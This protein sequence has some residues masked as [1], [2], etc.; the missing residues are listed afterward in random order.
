[1]STRWNWLV[2]SPE[3][4]TAENRT[5]NAINLVTFLLVCLFACIQLSVSAAPSAVLFLPAIGLQI[6]LYYFSRVHRIYRVPIIL[7]GVAS[8]AFIISSYFLHGGVNGPILLLFFL[9]AHVLI[10]FSKKKERI[11]MLLASIVSGLGVLFVEYKNPQ[12]VTEVYSDSH[13]RV[14]EIGAYYVICL[15]FIYVITIF[16]RNNYNRE[17]KLALKRESALRDSE[18]ILRRQNETL[19]KIAFTQSH[20]FRGPLATIMQ[21]IALIKLEDAYN[22][23]E[24][25]ELLETAVGDLDQKIREVVDISRDLDSI[26]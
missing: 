3:V 24:Y 10:A 23:K 13:Q 19:S 22:N 14:I 12:Y 15:V 1:M 25:F 7:Y 6:F 2:G 11:Y 18:A 5:F 21:V 4:F 20:E 17:R 8:Y 26:S 9:S 16:L